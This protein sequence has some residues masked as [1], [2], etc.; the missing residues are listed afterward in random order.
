MTIIPQN[1]YI[2]C[3][4]LQGNKKEVVSNGFS[5]QTDDI[6]IYKIL[7]IGSKVD[8]TLN[9]NQDDIVIF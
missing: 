3:K 6:P 7:S 5:Y 9:L 2:L 8:K 4:Q 1:S